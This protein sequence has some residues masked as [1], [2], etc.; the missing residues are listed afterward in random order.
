MSMP[1][2]QSGQSR[3]SCADSERGIRR[4]RP[5]SVEHGMFCDR[6][7][8]VA[9]CIW[10][11][12]SWGEMCRVVASDKRR[13]R[14]PSRAAIFGGH[15]AVLFLMGICVVCFGAV[16]EV[17]AGFGDPAT[18]AGLE[19]KRLDPA[20]RDRF[21]K[22]APQAWTALKGRLKAFEVRVK[23]REEW[24]APR[25][26]RKTS[27][28]WVYCVSPDGGRK[29]VV[30][31]DSLSILGANERYT[32]SVSRTA[33]GMPFA[34]NDCIVWKPGTSQPLIGDLSRSDAFL[35]YMWSIWWV[36]LD[37][38][39]S[40]DGFKLTAAESAVN[41]RGEEVVRV[42]YRYEG[43]PIENPHCERGAVYWAELLPS[44]LWA[45]TS[46]GVAGISQRDGTALNLR[47]TST[48]QDWFGEGPFPKLVLLEYEDST[49]HRIVEFRETKLDQPQPFTRS[50]DEYFLP[51]YGISENS[52]PALGAPPSWRVKVVS[53]GLL[54]VFAALFV[55]WRTIYRRIRVQPA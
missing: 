23:N 41:H 18:L 32:F 38:I 14:R 1:G 11:P 19:P 26:D 29:M 25:G 36:P 30:A 5:C 37:Y 46:S 4:A 39:L 44:R 12:S 40:T 24:N 42:A 50:S 9:H 54:G 55:L 16:R 51:N 10:S 15:T 48:L 33:E 53:L 47:V 13:S 35:D 45:V 2:E 8:V 43:H 34:L 20:C 28:E 21:L 31:G 3:R 17:H 27:N 22:D 7:W 49:K 52:V 6:A